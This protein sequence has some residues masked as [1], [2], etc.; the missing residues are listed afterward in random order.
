MAEKE[1]QFIHPPNNLRQKQK[2]A[3]VTGTVDAGWMEAA[4][5]S[6]LTAKFDYLTAA[7]E[8]LTR[9]QAAYD[10][11]LKDPA[12]RAE[13]VRALYAEV[14]A[15][16]GQGS[17]FGYPLMS[18]VGSQLARFI[19]DCGDTLTNAQ[20]DVVKVH[21]EALRLIIQ[22]KMEGEGGPIGQKIVAGLGAV[23]KKVAGETA[24]P[25]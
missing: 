6:M 11:A 23:I 18:A 1:I 8:D 20:M 21:V 10:A 17:S 4:E 24:A 9:L 7:Q 3:G 15:V 25:Q 16:K 22:Q 19:E 12:N 13:H 2:M 5:R 14:Q